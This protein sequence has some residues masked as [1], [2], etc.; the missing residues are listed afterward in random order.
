MA[1][2]EYVRDTRTGQEYSVQ[3]GNQTFIGDV[4]VT[5]TL[6]NNGSSVGVG[7]G[8]DES[9][10]SL[11]DNATNNASTTKHGFLKKLSNVASEFMN[12]AGNWASLVLPV[13]ASGAEVDT[14]TDDAKF[15]T[16]K[17]MEDSDYI[18]EADLPP[19]GGITNSAPANT[20]PSTA[21]GD[22][23]LDA[24]QLTDDGRALAG[25]A[26]VPA[27]VTLALAVQP[28]VGDTMT[29]GSRSYEFVAEATPPAQGEIALGADL[30][31]TQGLV[32]IMI[33]S[34]AGY[35]NPQVS[36]SD[37]V[38][39]VS[40]LTARAIGTAGNGI[41]VSETFTSGS[42]LFSA[43]ETSGGVDE[44]GYLEVG[45]DAA[46]QGPI[47]V[48][49]QQSLTAADSIGNTRK[50]IQLMAEGGD[51]AVVISVPAMPDDQ[52]HLIS[53]KS[54]DGAEEVF[55]F[56][57]DGDADYFL[58]E[59]N[60]AQFRWSS[61]DDAFALHQLVS[62]D[63]ESFQVATAF[64]VQMDGSGIFLNDQVNISDVL[65]LTPKAF[66]ALPASP[67]EGMM[68]WV[69]DSNTATWGAT[70]ADGGANKVLAVFNGTVWTVAGK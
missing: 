54:S 40:T 30:A 38:A 7:A 22:G 60:G 20:V 47:R 37:W 67:A 48:G 39:N 13:K 58:Y 6:T 34:A 8:V 3:R 62:I 64:A 27:T 53:F 44:V 1:D 29:I 45:P 25:A 42:N 31:T 56:S 51:D 68:A 4:E 12:G 2:D 24:S 32:Q 23:N 63:A 50:L 41:E 11:S 26:A 19:G 52:E 46:P 14:G 18:K 9:E 59:V 69:N 17:A 35:A 5:G 61:V 15:V 55:V 36:A 33:N 21:D 28:T 16:A 66:A 10:I 65:K 49:Y 43:V 57:S 70:I